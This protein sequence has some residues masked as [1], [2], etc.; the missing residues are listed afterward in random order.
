MHK[1]TLLT[2]LFILSGWTA[3]AGEIRLREKVDCDNAI[4]RLS[5]IADVHAADALTTENL[6]AIALFPTP[7]GKRPRTLRRQEVQELLALS[8][9]PLKDYRFTGAESVSVQAKEIAL[10]TE[11]KPGRN[12]LRSPIAQSATQAGGT[13][14][15]Q[16]NVQ[17]A[18][19]TV[20][21]LRQG[22]VIQ[23]SDVQL[24]LA[25]EAVANRASGVALEEIVGKELTR[26]L[27]AGQP[28]QPD[29]LQSPRLVQRG[30]VVKIQSIAAGVV[31]SM[32]GKAMEAGGKGDVIQVEMPDDRERIFARIVDRR[33]VAVYA[34]APTFTGAQTQAK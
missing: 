4:V 15:S 5:D 26:S 11:T 9:V 25:T 29:V 18:V 16:P 22:M 33:T 28:V 31:V 2:I 8:D 10:A 23:A 1:T 34:Q 17:L 19:Y 13:A 12:V 7:A 20:R 3:D 6:N 21:P 14:A 30:E 24:Q 27:A 32:D